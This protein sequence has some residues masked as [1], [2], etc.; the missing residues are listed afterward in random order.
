MM[1]DLFSAPSRGFELAAEQRALAE[2]FER[3]DGRERCLLCG[4]EENISD[5]WSRARLS[6]AAWYVQDFCYP[7]LLSYSID[8][9]NYK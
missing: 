5:G 1:M 9:V 2:V 8:G 7:L 4:G 3:R 6:S